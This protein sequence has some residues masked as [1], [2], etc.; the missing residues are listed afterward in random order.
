MKFLV[1]QIQCGIFLSAFD[2]LPRTK[3]RVIDVVVETIPELAEVDPII[4]PQGDNFPAEIPTVILRHATG[5]GWLFQYAPARCDFVY[6][7]TQPTQSDQLTDLLTQMKS[8]ITQCWE[9]FQSEFGW[10]SPRLGLVVNFS[11]SLERPSQLI[12]ERYFQEGLVNQPTQ[13]LLGYMTHETPQS[14]P[15]LNHWVRVQTHP[16]GE[17]KS[18]SIAL[19]V[20]INTDNRT[21]FSV[22]PTSLSKF[23]DDA[24]QLVAKDL[25]FHEE[26]L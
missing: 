1:D 7:V 20:D 21:E 19:N 6:T 8:F 2:H 24:Q 12:T 11:T 23:F 25:K 15:P 17:P 3:L 4:L 5:Q 18:A 22:T 14:S 13:A 26:R 10:Q 9:R 16:L